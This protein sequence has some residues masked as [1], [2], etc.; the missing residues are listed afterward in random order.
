MLD[1]KG[2]KSNDFVFLC[3]SL[4]DKKING[5]S[6]MILRV[7]C[8]CSKGSDFIL[9]SF[10]FS[11]SIFLH[12]IIIWC[13]YYSYKIFPFLEVFIYLLHCKYISTKY[14]VEFVV[15][16]NI[17][18]LVSCTLCKYRNMCV[19][20]HMSLMMEE[21]QILTKALLHDLLPETSFTK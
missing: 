1:K 4:E 9:C 18:R 15:L 3:V 6:K 16:K 12:N 11:S 13:Y 7:C 14:V 8:F 5:Y 10:Y 17:Y 20:V 19:S 21:V 2:Y